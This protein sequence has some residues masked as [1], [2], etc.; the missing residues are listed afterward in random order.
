MHA[1][2]TPNPKEDL[3]SPQTWSPTDYYPKYLRYDTWALKLPKHWPRFERWN[4]NCTSNP[5]YLKNMDQCIYCNEPALANCFVCSQDIC[6]RHLRHI[7]DLHHFRCMYCAS[8]DRFSRKAFVLNILF[9]YHMCL[10][11]C[12]TTLLMVKGSLYSLFVLVTRQISSLFF[13]S[14]NANWF[15]QGV[16]YQK[17]SNDDLSRDQEE[18]VQSTWPVRTR[19]TSL[20]HSWYYRCTQQVHRWWRVLRYLLRVYLLQRQRNHKTGAPF[21]RVSQHGR[22][23]RRGYHSSQRINH[24]IGEIRIDGHWWTSESLWACSPK[25]L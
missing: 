18:Y 15:S 5:N 9:V 10:R 22:S 2:E 19:P 25:H 21:C 11:K 13:F 24:S 1:V 14:F 4:W 6:E 8:E 7:H 23:H 16:A 17:S 3:E 12:G 20:Y